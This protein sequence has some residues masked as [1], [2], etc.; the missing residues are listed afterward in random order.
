MTLFYKKTANY[1]LYRKG[2]GSEAG[3]AYMAI[4]ILLAILSTLTFA[5]I[6]RVGTQTQATLTRGAGIQA[7]YLA[8]TAANHA[9]WRLLNDPGF[10]E[11]EDVYYMHS[12]GGDRYGYKVIRPTATTF[13][14]IATVGATGESVVHQSYVPYIIPEKVM[15]VYVDWWNKTDRY[16]R[17]VGAS[18]DAEKP[19]FWISAWEPK[20][21]ELEGHPFAD[22]F[23]VG[24][25]DEFDYIELGV[26]DGSSWGNTLTFTGDSKKDHKCFDIA[27]DTY[28]GHAFVFGAD[29]TQR[30]KVIYTVW[31]GSNWIAPALAFDT[32][33]G[34]EIRYID[35]EGSHISGEILISVL[36]Q[37]KDISLHRWD[38]ATFAKLATLETDAA[39]DEGMQVNITYEQQSGEAL[40][41]WAVNYANTCYYRTWDGSTLS[42]ANPLPT[43]GNK[44]WQIKMAPD[45]AS[46]TIVL[47][48]VDDNSDLDAA[49]WDGST[50]TDSTVIEGNLEQNPEKE[51]LNFEAAWEESGS[52]AI[53]A[54]GQNGNTNVMYTRW[55]KAMAL[56]SC[57]AE[58]GPDFAYKL[59]GGMRMCR[60]PGSD[61][62]VLM[63]TNA[64]WDL[65]YCLWDGDSLG[66]NPAVLQI[67][68]QP[69]LIGC[70]HDIAFPDYLA[71]PTA[72]PT[73][74]PVIGSDVLCDDLLGYWKLDETSGTNAS[75]SSGNGNNGTLTSMDPSTD[76]V[77]GKIEGAL[78]FDGSNDVVIVPH[79]EELSLTEEYTLA[80][81]IYKHSLSSYD[82]AFNKGSSGFDSNYFFGTVDRDLTFGFYRSGWVEFK[83]TGLNLQTYT[84]YHI[85]GIFDNANNNVR[86]YLN[87]VEVLNETTTQ[88]P[89][90]NTGTVRLGNPQW[91][92]N[93]HGALDDVRIYNRALDPSEIAQLHAL[94]EGS[95]CSGG[96]GGGCVVFEEFT[97]GKRSSN[98]NSITISTPAGTNGGDLLIA[99]VATDGNTTSSLAPPGG[100]GWSE[101]EFDNYSNYLTLGVWYK[102]ADASEAASHQ[103]TWS[104][105]GQQA[106]GWMMR[107]TGHD[108]TTPINTSA[109]GGYVWSSTPLSP[110]VSTT[111]ENAL[112]LRLGGFDD[113]DISLDSTGLPLDH[114]TITMDESI[115]GYG[116][117][118]GGA[119]YI[120][121]AATG[122][123]GTANFLLTASEQYITVTIAIA[124]AP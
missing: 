104:G 18:F 7:D 1:I 36:Y 10:P 28:N 100:E 43:F 49:V 64:N 19:T 85:A 31:D 103:F 61:R 90:S 35:A 94:T 6:F 118:S 34:Q 37:N 98:G 54:W 55:N 65:K 84:W 80:A 68:A 39:Y 58:T 112:I 96:G 9:M 44:V 57:I 46:D 11:N 86:L 42:A 72:A 73:P 56:S 3:M 93:F 63:S 48:A 75:D 47:L 97:E 79:S 2:N 77:G 27:Y 123:S 107:F 76:W 87:G 116:T 108:P 89:L 92:S 117:A 95:D 30:G 8:E 119:G 70:P 82:Q 22:E 101:I 14:A 91:S 51:Y 109:V 106:Y 20:W 29:D 115:L 110:S 23:V 78:D 113:D 120:C 4:L 40:I 21:V 99:A 38:G 24:F 71:G 67:Y 122:D 88:E 33:S 5:F 17:M 16:R 105:T 60:V 12:L 15:T 102:I 114:T 50:W 26:W 32:G 62:I 45:P 52:E 74:N 121:Q 25:L 66:G 53:I 124:P 81:W 41:V 83:T 59:K 69:W 13:A 111:V